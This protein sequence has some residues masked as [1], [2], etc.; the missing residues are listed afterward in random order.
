MDFDRLAVA[1]SRRRL[2]GSSLAAAVATL[3]MR[4][5]AQDGPRVDRFV[6]VDAGTDA[7]VIVLSD[8][9]VIFPED[10]PNGLNVRAETTPENVGP[11]AFFLDG[12]LARTE[13]NP[14]YALFGNTGNDY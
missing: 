3:P 9:S 5:L 12:A 1:L 14:V 11:V 8:G 6:L 2:L 7:D 4:G 10:F 13:N